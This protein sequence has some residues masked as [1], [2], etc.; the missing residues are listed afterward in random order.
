MKNNNAKA[1]IFR[2]VTGRRPFG[3]GSY[4]RPI[5]NMNNFI[6]SLMYLIRGNK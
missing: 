5:E 3:I 6:G 4:S 2:F 1:T